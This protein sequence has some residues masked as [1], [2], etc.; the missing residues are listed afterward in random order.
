MKRLIAFFFLCGFFFYGAALSLRSS[1]VARAYQANGKID[2][3]RDIRPILSDNCFQCHGPDDK[4]RMAKLRFD[5]KEGAFAKAGVI[6]A[7]DA[8]NSRLIKRVT[9]TDAD[10]VMPPP[11]TGHKLT[12]AQIATL[13]RWIDEG[14]AWES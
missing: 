13:K 7:G 11:A 14:A 2:F 3:N 9:S 4:A 6:I 1:N 12:E 8:A 10:L 5:T